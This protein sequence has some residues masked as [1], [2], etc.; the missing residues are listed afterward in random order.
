M[1]N[2]RT[3]ASVARENRI[4]LEDA[5]NH[6]TIR[7][8]MGILERF[9]IKITP[10]FTFPFCHE[11]SRKYEPTN[12]IVLEAIPTENDPNLYCWT[13]YIEFKCPG[14]GNVHLKEKDSYLGNSKAKK[15][16]QS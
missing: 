4:N 13:E 8:E 2:L 6:I 15:I 5:K 11:D 16:K 14:C 9:L 7:K 10:G 3:I 12:S 1:K